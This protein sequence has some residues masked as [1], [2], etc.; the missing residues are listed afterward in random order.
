MQEDDALLGQGKSAASLVSERMRG[1]LSAFLA[2]FLT[3]LDE[4][5]DRRLVRT[6]LLTVEAVLSFRNR[7]S[8]LLLSELGGYLLSAEHSVR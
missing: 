3:E 5:L 6:L 4:Y 8:G 2:P 1:R 7:A